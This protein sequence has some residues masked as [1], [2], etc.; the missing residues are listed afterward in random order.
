[1][2]QEVYEEPMN[3]PI[4]DHP[5]IEPQP[6]QMQDG[7]LQYQLEVTELVDEIEHTLRQEEPVIDG[8]SVVWKARKAGKGKQTLKPLCSEEFISH[9]RLILKSRLTKVFALSDLDDHIISSMTIE[10][11]QEI[12]KKICLDWWRCDIRDTSTAKIILHMITDQVYAT[13]RKAH[14]ANY[15]DFLK[16]TSKI[17][18]TM[19]VGQ[20]KVSKSPKDFD[21]RM[22]FKRR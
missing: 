3:Y 13:L 12:M 21:P 14:N 6:Q 1:M 17:Q 16:T 20:P 19:L 2:Q 15:L 5:Y 10:V 9:V 8:N 7:I 18:Q 22:I 11:A 4:P